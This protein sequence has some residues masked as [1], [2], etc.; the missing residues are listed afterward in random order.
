M[1]EVF[2]SSA[3]GARTGGPEAVHQLTHALRSH[4]IRASLIPMRGFRGNSPHIDYEV[5]D[6]EV[7]DR[8]P[9]KSNHRLIV[10]EISPLESWRELRK[11]PKENTWMWWLSVNNA[12]DQRARYFSA[13]KKRSLVKPIWNESL[14]RANP[15]DSFSHKCRVCAAEFISLNYSK[16]LL[17]SNIRFL[18][19]SEYAMDF[20]KLEMGN[21][22]MLVSDYLRELPAINPGSVR[23]SVVTYNGS[24]G[25]SKIG[26]I[27]RRFPDIQFIPIKGL[28]YVEVCEILAQSMAYLELGHLPGRDRLPREAGRLGTPIILLQRG[29][30]VYYEDFPVSDQFRVSYTQDWAK[31]MS[32]VLKD[33]LIDRAYAVKEQEGFRE[34]VLRDRDR[35][36][37]EV[38]EWI[39]LLMK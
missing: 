12:P 5:Y 21:P 11:T 6:Y 9:K 16:R 30:G 13:S 10:T 26:E 28:N 35:F 15:M 14:Q 37:L 27:E 32:R 18:A 22:A 34:W 36:N 2:V 1:T 24:R 38:E 25:Y 17:A 31:N 7:T 29:A 23:K 8:I 3:M 4:G 39:P 19:Q 20:C 33:L